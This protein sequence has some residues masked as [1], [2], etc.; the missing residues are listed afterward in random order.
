MEEQTLHI[1]PIYQGRVVTLELHQVMLP[2]GLES[3]RELIKHPGA[4]A[5]V[6]LDEEGRV[7]LVRQFR[8]AAAKVLYEIPAGTLNPN[9][10]PLECADR[11]LREETGFQPLSLEP[12]GGIYMAPGYTTEYLHLFFAPAVQPAPLPPDEDEQ[13]EVTHA[14][15]SEV[16]GMIEN[17]TIEDS[18]SVSALLKVARKLGV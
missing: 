12:I 18:K 10:P 9:E 13:I 7:L 4:V 2:N 15:W 3:K 11:E 6:A 8:Y 16:L 1:T 14:T 5:I 17:G